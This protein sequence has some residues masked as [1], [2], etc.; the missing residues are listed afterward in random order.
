MAEYSAVIYCNIDGVDTS[1]ILDTVR[2]TSVTETSTVTTHPMVNR[3]I[4]ADH[5]Y[6]NPAS[7]TLSGSFSLNGSKGFMVT[8]GNT[9]LVDVQRIFQRIKEEGIV[10]NIAK[11]SMNDDKVRF[12]QHNNFVLAN[13]TWTEKI[14][15][16]DFNFTFD[17][18]LFA[19]VITA[20]VDI[21]DEFLPDIEYPDSLS[22][23]DEL[24]DVQQVLELFEM[25]LEK[26]NVVT[27]GFKAFLAGQIVGPLASLGIALTVAKLMISLGASTGPVGLVVG[28]IAS[29]ITIAI[30]A[31]F[32]IVKTR[33]KSK[34]IKQFKKEVSDA[35]NNKELVRY[36]DLIESFRLSLDKLNDKL[37]VYKVSANKSQ[38]CIITINDSLHVFKFVK[39]NTQRDWLLSIEDSRRTKKASSIYVSTIAAE[40]LEQASNPEKIICRGGDDNKSGSYVYLIRDVNVEDKYDLTGYYIFV[41]D[42]DL[43][44]L[45]N[46]ITDLI[47]T[48]I[49]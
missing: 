44:E 15:S 14:N 25:E 32:V 36:A 2:D 7:L 24:L 26:A 8:A 18:V 17:Q 22:F 48:T 49:Y 20:D 28:I 10:C 12:L 34:K 3:D 6:N 45:T 35:K 1:L 21:S 29:V 23:T 47:K 4:V 9:E 39:A 16:L 43:S 41:A 37:H 5:M 30:T 33:N 13:I 40:D 42:Y 11:I 19:D 46:S 31:I 38:E 27:D